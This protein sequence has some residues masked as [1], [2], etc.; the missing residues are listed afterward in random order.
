MPMKLSILVKESFYPRAASFT[1]S[2]FYKVTFL[3]IL[4]IRRLSEVHTH[5]CPTDWDLSTSKLQ[6]K[7]YQMCLL[8]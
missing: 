3:M 1:E 2:C 5:L 6:S 8:N 7:A 4:S